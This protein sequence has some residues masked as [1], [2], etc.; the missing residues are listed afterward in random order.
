M[1]DIASSANLEKINLA[2]DESIGRY[3]QERRIRVESFTERHF[4]WEGAR[5]LHKKAVGWDMVR[6]PANVLLAV[7]YLVF[8]RG[9]G[10]LAS[11]VGATSTAAYLA[12]LPPGV[13]TDLEREIEWLIYSELLELPFAHN[14]RKYTRDALF[15]TILQHPNASDL[16]VSELLR[17]NDQAQHRDFREHLELYLCQYTNSRTAAADFCNSLLSIA[18]GVTVF[19]QFTPGALAIGTSTATLIANQLAITHFV[20]G[21]A[22]GTLYYGLFPASASIGLLT[23]TT[24]GVMVLLGLLSTFAGVVFDPLQQSLG[25]HSKRL[26]ALLDTL[27]ARLEGQESN[28]ELR[29]AYVARIFDVLDLLKAASQVLNR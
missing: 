27:E 11:Q 4:S 14:E 24:G 9:G 6:T 17:I 15:E 29:D 12:S 3:I 23:A 21:P 26:F 5:Q 22:L 10:Y 8:V 20:L 18:A 13:R 1:T 16:V 19:K 2:V 25:L 28:Y 7:P